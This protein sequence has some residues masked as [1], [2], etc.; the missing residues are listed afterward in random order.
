[1]DTANKTILY[2]RHAALGARLVE[3]GG[4]LMPVQYDGIL[5]EHHR[6]RHAVSLFDTCH[7]GAFLIEGAGALD[8]LSRIL[9]QDLRTL[10]DGRLR[11]GFL[12]NEEAGVLDDLIAYR[13]AADRWMVVVNAGT[14]D[15]DYAWLA[16]HL[17]PSVK[18]TNLAGRQGK[19]DVQGPA[20]PAAV[21]RVLGRDFA[22]LPY[23]GCTACEAGGRRV[24]V[25][26]SGYTGEVGFELYADPD[27][28]LWLW[29]AL[30]ANGVQP[31]GLGARDTLRLEAGLPLYG[32]ELSTA[33]T[34]V[35][36]GFMRYAS[37]AEPFIG[38]AALQQRLVQGPRQ[39]LAGLRLD[40][41]QSP[42]HGNRVLQNGA[43]AGW[44][45][46]GSFAPTLGWAVALAYLRTELAVPGAR[47]DV[48]AERR[49][50]GG[51][52][53]DVPFYRRPAPQ[54]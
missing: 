47:I 5:A 16:A 45:T 11:Y 53:V 43:D 54:P 30:L 13:W 36:A 32:H 49:T 2:D 9:T 39:R 15:G 21:A 27:A 17:P 6:T 23:F 48:N 35:E 19:L 42:R 22:A 31:A 46:S 18:L 24:L 10:Q 3:F 4:W 38:R 50:L 7:M 28:I 40:G 20:A 25:S 33:V 8:A 37:K 29:D 52:I 14:Q 44:V 41:R 34:P 26:R 1:M 12:L 51:M